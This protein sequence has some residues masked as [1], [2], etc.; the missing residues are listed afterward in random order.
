MN[1]LEQYLIDVEFPQVSGIEQLEMLR[2][3]S[4]IDANHLAPAD[5]LRL[6]EADRLLLERAPQF[7]AELAR[8]VDLKAERIRRNIGSEEW[9]W[10]LDVIA[11]MPLTATPLPA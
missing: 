7:A 9:W 1:K 6:A 11:E 10:Y 3:R 4:E 2:T 5:R 8:F